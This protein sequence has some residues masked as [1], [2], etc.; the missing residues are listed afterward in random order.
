MIHQT[1]GGQSL[2]QSRV[3][4]LTQTPNSLVLSIQAEVN[5][6]ILI[7][8]SSC[9]S[10]LNS[11]LLIL[12]LPVWEHKRLVIAESLC[13]TENL[14]FPVLN[15]SGDQQNASFAFSGRC[16]GHPT[17]QTVASI[18]LSSAVVLSQVCI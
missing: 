5:L 15:T 2:E 12:H 14:L 11:Y 9:V 13:F 10:L 6:V 8:W 18:H 1:L 4:T 3:Y 16:M 17:V 7:H